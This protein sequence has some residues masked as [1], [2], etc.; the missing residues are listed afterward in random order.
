MKNANGGKIGLIEPPFTAI[1]IDS[2]DLCRCWS[3]RLYIL[4]GNKRLEN[5]RGTGWCLSCTF[6]LISPSPFPVFRFY[7]TPGCSFLSF[8]SSFLFFIYISPGS[9]K[10]RRNYSHLKS[11]SFLSPFVP[12][13]LSLFVVL[14]FPFLFVSFSPPPPPPLSPLEIGSKP[15]TL[16]GDCNRHWSDDRTFGRTLIRQL[17]SGRNI[18]F[19]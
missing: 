13:S 5:K 17:K 15:V 8:F 18:V 2:I 14:F 11:V 7:A 9:I 4:P 12:L 1:V 6:K 10:F 16:V 19:K 3:D